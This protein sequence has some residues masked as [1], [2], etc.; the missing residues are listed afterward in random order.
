M[1]ARK[2]QKHIL[3]LLLFWAIQW[4]LVPTVHAA[5]PPRFIEETETSGIQHSYEGEFRYLAGAGV[6]VFDCNGDELPEIYLAGGSEPA[7]LYQNISRAGGFL[8][9]KRIENS[10]P[11]SVVI[12]CS[13]SMLHGCTRVP[14]AVG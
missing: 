3:S 9:F 11:S 10:R 12:R 7:A 6:V 2:I 14:R 5:G 13:N 8:K 4:V 1:K